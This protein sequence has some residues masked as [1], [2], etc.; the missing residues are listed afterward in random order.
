MPIRRSHP[1]QTLAIMV[2]LS[3]GAL[4]FL[5]SAQTAP[6]ML[7][8]K[9]IDKPNGQFGFEPAT[10][11]AQTGDTIRFVQASTAPH[12][13]HFTKTPTGVRLGRAISGPYVMAANQSYDLILDTRFSA[14]TYQFVCDPH[15][16][17][18]MTGTLTVGPPAA[19][20][21]PSH[22]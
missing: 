11:S 3:L 18:G 6:H 8:V 5:A 17:V 7:V 2:A 15:Q 4:P 21:R 16:T 14:G 10:I 12:N 9:M 22:F 1:L 19:T 13:V 20:S